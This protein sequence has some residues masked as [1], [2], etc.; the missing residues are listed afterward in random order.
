MTGDIA[1]AGDVVSL[2]EGM[3]ASISKTMR[4]NTWDQAPRL[5]V[6]SVSDAAKIASAC[7]A[8]GAQ[9]FVRFHRAAPPSTASVPEFITIE[10]I[11]A[12]SPARNSTPANG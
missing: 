7:G 3:Y 5:R 12:L 8:C 2:A 6:T 9:L 10:A 1:Q 11:G 4:S